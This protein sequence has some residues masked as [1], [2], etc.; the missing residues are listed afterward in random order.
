MRAEAATLFWR[1]VD[2]ELRSCFEASLPTRFEVF[3]FLAI[4]KILSNLGYVADLVTSC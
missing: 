1:L 4:A 3:S 2:L